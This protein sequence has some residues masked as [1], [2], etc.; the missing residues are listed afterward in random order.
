M[1]EPFKTLLHQSY[2]LHDVLNT[3]AALET[4]CK[5][6]KTSRIKDAEASRTSREAYC[7]YPQPNH[8]RSTTLSRGFL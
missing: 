5:A 7:Q 1:R 6:I 3:D 4:I 8:L 2:Q